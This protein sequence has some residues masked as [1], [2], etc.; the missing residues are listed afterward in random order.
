MTA[1]TIES[2]LLVSA[3]QLADEA[4]ERR[5]AAPARRRRPVGRP[6]VLPATVKPVRGG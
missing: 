1:P 6:G 2:A 5:W 3:R 4:Q